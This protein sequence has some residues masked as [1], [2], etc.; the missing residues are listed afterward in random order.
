MRYRF[1]TRP[2]SAGFVLPVAIFLLVTLASLAAFMLHV[3]GQTHAAQA[4]DIQSARGYQAARVGIERGLWSVLQ[5]ATCPAT[6]QNL[7]LT[8]DLNGFAV[9][10]TCSA[11]AFSEGGQSRT[12]YRI[13]STATYNSGPAND[14]VERQLQALTER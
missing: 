14:A 12:Q 4:L 13:V 1:P 11:I 2:E 7:T 9:S 5:G 8:G 10:W 6:A 3:S